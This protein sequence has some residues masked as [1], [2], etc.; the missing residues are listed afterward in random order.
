MSANKYHSSKI[1]K[2]LGYALFEKSK[3]KMT[4]SN[5]IPFS[6]TWLDLYILFQ[7]RNYVYYFLCK[8]IFISNRFKVKDRY[9][10]NRAENYE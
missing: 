7:K 8:N 10:I 9:T 2:S 3:S 5:W 4:F 1:S 6:V